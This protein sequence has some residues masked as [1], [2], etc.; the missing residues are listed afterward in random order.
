VEV[1]RDRVVA[2]PP[3]NTFLAEKM[4]GQTHIAHL[5]GSFRHMPAVK[6]E[7]LVQVLRRVSEMVCELPEIMS[8]DINPLIAD[9]HGVVA[10]DARIQVARQAPSLDRYDHMAIHPY[11]NHLVTRWQLADGINIKVR[12][13][14]PE[15]ASIEQSFVRELSPQS[16]YFRFMQGLNELTQQMLVRF[17][18]LD[19]NRELALIAV[20]E[21]PDG[22]KELGV[23]RYVMKPDGESCEFAL[24][25]ADN[26]QH[27]GIGSRLMSELIEAAR[28]H[29]IKIME[30]EIL[31]SN[32]N[33]LALASSLGFS[34]HVS[35]DDMAIMVASRVL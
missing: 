7:A 27:R 19:Y 12:P 14:R 22:E 29:G 8:L 10:L 11:P 25:V 21:G 4:I 26:W 17:T 28:Q 24:V 32:R 16:K 15:D 33:M 18:Q 30:G 5:L 1:V 31:A 2:L 13:I 35:D 3:L 23:A 20:V 9:E 6:M 34:L